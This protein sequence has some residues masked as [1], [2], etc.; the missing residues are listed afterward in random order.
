MNIEPSVLF[1]LQLTIILAACRLVGWFARY[2]GQPAVVGEMVAGVLLGPSLFG[3]LVPG[4]HAFVFPSGSMPILFGLSQLGLTLYMFV[5]GLDFQVNHFWQHGKAAASVSVVGMIAPFVLG[6]I[7]AIWLHGSGGF[8][9]EKTGVMEAIL[10]MGAAMS[11][12]AF[13]ML[14]RIIHENALSGTSLGTL[15]LAAGAIDDAAA[16]CVLALLLSCSNGDPTQA[17]ITIFGGI[18][19][20]AT[21]LLVLRPW[22]RRLLSVSEP[23]GKLSSGQLASLLGL[24]MLGACVTNFLGIHSVFGA[25][26]IGCAIPRGLVCE[27]LKKQIEPLTLCLL[28][29]LFFTYSGLNTRLDLVSTPWLLMV[30]AI[31]FLAACL[32]KGFACWAAA[33]WA[34]ENQGTSLAVGCLMNARGMMGLILLIIG[35]ERGIIGPE[36]FSILVLVAILTTLVATPVFR[37]IQVRYSVQLD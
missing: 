29:P 11:I 23:H 22:L 36:L 3:Q 32:G 25:F 5:V 28:V 14:A 13:P 12:T 35:N 37:W 2:L 33:R 9:T 1:F 21:V 16:W 26:I 8:F 15:A 18:A 30:A 4:L 7:I 17:F 19:Y 31:T 27:H 10:F 34:G 6:G 20:T 24:V